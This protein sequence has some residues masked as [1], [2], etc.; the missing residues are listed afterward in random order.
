MMQDLSNSR[1]LRGWAAAA[2]V[3]ALALSLAA[4]SSMGTSA[5][6]DGAS[7]EGKT[8]EM[9]VGYAP[10]GSYD[11]WMRAVQPYFEENTGATTVV[12]NEPGAG[13]LL[14]LAN[15]YKASG[16]EVHIG[17]VNVP[18]VVGPVLADAPGVNF[19][20]DDFKW[21]GNASGEPEIMVVAGDSDITSFEDFVD[22]AQE[23][24]EPVKLGAPGPDNYYL[25]ALV[26]STLFDFPVEVVTGYDGVGAVFNA[27]MQ[28]DL[29]AAVGTLTTSQGPVES[30]ELRPLTAIGDLPEGMTDSDLEEIMGASVPAVSELYEEFGVGTPDAD[31]ILDMHQKV[32][33][34]GRPF[35]AAPST[36][37]EDLQALRDAYT[38]MVEDP[39][40]AADMAK[41]NLYP[42]PMPG[43]EVKSLMDELL[44][45]P[46]S[47][48]D[49]VR[50]AYS[51]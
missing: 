23:S 43:D 24:G 9:H 49:L 42:K 36:S 37:D 19:E 18:G 44:D 40:Y 15:V 12:R 10:G 16:R 45:A 47:Y 4:C 35:V 3:A 51:E 28:G 21:I 30:D 5:G 13:G 39:G 26:L 7:L 8:V 20:L 22:Q 38:S 2:G 14:A 25:D 33:R 41:L 31:E 17:N 32:L 29:D 27:V 46:E 6:E 50:E 1:T 11:Q 48:A 34:V